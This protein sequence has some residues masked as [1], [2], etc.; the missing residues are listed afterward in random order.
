MAGGIALKKTSDMFKPIKNINI[1]FIQPRRD[2]LNDTDVMIFLKVG[3]IQLCRAT[4][5]I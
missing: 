3:N 5:Y 4:C 2:Y 1:L